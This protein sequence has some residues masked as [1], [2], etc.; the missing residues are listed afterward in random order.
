[1]NT[2]VRIATWRRPNAHGFISET[3]MQAV[4]V[5]SRIYSYR[6]NTHLLTRAYN[7]KGNFTT[8]SYQYLFKHSF[9]VQISDVQMCELRMCKLL[10]F[11]IFICTF[12][13]LHIKTFI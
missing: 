13:Y 1:M 9:D 10:I 7:T 4:P 5:G 8:V 12:A 6:F 3:H 2:Q 11:M